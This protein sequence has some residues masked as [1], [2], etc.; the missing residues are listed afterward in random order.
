MRDDDDDA[1]DDDSGGGGAGRIDDHDEDAQL[2]EPMTRTLPGDFDQ[3]HTQEQESGFDFAFPLILTH[4]CP[5][6]SDEVPTS[7]RALLRC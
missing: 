6:K 3:A 1:D 7:A 4:S 5:F 2:C